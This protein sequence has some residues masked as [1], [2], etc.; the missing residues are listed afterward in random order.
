MK[1]NDI[2][3]LDYYVAKKTETL[4]QYKDLIRYGVILL[5]TVLV[6][7]GLTLKYVLDESVI[8]TKMDALTAN[9]SQ[10]EVVAQLAESEKI[11]KDMASLDNIESQ[12][13][14]VLAVL[15]QIPRYDDHVLDTLHSLRT[16]NVHFTQLSY[17]KNILTIDFY[18]HMMLTASAYSLRVLDSGR[19][20]DCSY[21]G[22]KYDETNGIYRGRIVC[23]LKGGQ[24]Q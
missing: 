13:T 21:T 7:G 1:R 4:V 9:L 18:E 6:T 15:D 14:E 24:N 10:P 19:F 12:L 22:Y 23:I 17:D 16:D 20:S 2:N 5:L 3:L 8:Q 11:T